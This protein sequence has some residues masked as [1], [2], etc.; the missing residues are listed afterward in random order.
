[1]TRRRVLGVVGLVA[2][3]AA[4]AVLADVWFLALMWG[5]TRSLYYVPD[6]GDITSALLIALVTVWV[7]AGLVLAPPRRPKNSRACAPRLDARVVPGR[8]AVPVSTAERR[9]GPVMSGAAGRH[10]PAAWPSRT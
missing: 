5:T 9:P 4:I 6:S 2:A 7:V 8:P 3:L 10:S 1:M